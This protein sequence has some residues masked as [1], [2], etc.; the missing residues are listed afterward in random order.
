LLHIFNISVQILSFEAN[1]NRNGCTF[2]PK[3]SQAKSSQV[4]SQEHDLLRAVQ[5]HHFHGI[6]NCINHI[7]KSAT[8]GSR[9]LRIIL[10]LH[11]ILLT[12]FI[13]LDTESLKSDHPCFGGSGIG[14]P[15][16]IATRFPLSLFVRNPIT[17]LYEDILN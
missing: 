4:L 13:V 7:L 5:I 6:L 15:L 2:V 16:S 14:S 9:R 11:L 17:T 12:E 3:S 8:F 1:D 10:A